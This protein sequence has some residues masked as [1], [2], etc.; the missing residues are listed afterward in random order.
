MD[1]E[2][3]VTSTFARTSTILWNNPTNSENTHHSAKCRS[4]TLKIG[5]IGAQPVAPYSTCM[6]VASMSA[7]PKQKRSAIARIPSLPEFR[8]QKGQG[9]SCTKLA[10]FWLRG[11]VAKVSSS[12]ARRNTDKYNVAMIVDREYEVP[13][14]DMATVKSSTGAVC[15]IIISGRVYGCST[16]WTATVHA[17]ESMRHTWRASVRAGVRAP[18]VIVRG[19]C[20][21]GACVVN[22]VPRAAPSPAQLGQPTHYTSFPP[23][24][25][26]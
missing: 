6:P 17:C 13:R 20:E 19:V 18:C 24:G 22:V 10:P 21:C 1:R 26:N 8:A 25:G 5:M 7:V 12:P 16:A 4:T 3:G 15:T 23:N 11:E 2:N 9:R 14:D